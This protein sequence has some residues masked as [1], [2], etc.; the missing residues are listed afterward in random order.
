MTAPEIRAVVFDFDGVIIDSE[1]THFETWAELFDRYGA[2][3]TVA[4]FIES[5][6]GRHVNIYEMLAGKATKPVPAEGDLR[7]IKRV[8][9]AELI[10]ATDVLPGVAD[11]VAEARRLGLRVGIASSA[12]QPWL[13]EHLA[14]IAMV[15]S[16]ECVCCWDDQIAAKPAP[17]LYLVACERLGVA[18]E[19]ALAIEDS[20]NGL[21]AARRAGMR[22]LAVVHRLT[23]E[24]ELAAD[25]V[26]RSLDE[27]TVT[28]ALE[29]LA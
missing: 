10:A 1:V 4:E 5:M 19:A 28:E 18:P 22:T 27:L 8:R 17:D 21:L 3:L 15:D 23:E 20:P 7:E 25:L 29:R 24:L 14:R 9:H 16:F 11:W 12:D 2:E 6:G 13:D 26:V